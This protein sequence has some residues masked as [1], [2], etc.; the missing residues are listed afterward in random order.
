MPLLRRSG[1]LENKMPPK[2]TDFN[3]PDQSFLS[4]LL[5]QYQESNT[6]LAKEFSTPDYK[7]TFDNEPVIA[8]SMHMA[9]PHS[10]IARLINDATKMDTQIRELSTQVGELKKFIQLSSVSQPHLEQ[11]VSTPITRVSQLCHTCAIN[12]EG[13]V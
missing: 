12:P 9:D 1:L 5:D 4:Q 7:V 3:L 11:I 13:A 2:A 10:L 8:K 6:R